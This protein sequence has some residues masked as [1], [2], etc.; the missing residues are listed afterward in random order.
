VSGRLVTIAKCSTE[1]EV[2]GLSAALR[3]AAI[4]HVVRRATIGAPGWELAVQ[5]IDS[6]RADEIVNDIYGINTREAETAVVPPPAPLQV[7]ESCGAT[8][9][10]RTPK[11]QIFLLGVVMSIGFMFVADTRMSR[12]SFFLIAGLAIAM[13]VMDKWRCRECGNSWK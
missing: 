3:L 11:L 12:I 10:A 7:C 9:I 2:D 8:D 13:L 6:D 5:S 1:A 4:E